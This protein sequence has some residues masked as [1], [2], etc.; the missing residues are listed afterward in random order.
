MIES[1]TTT[2]RH[3]IRRTALRALAFAYVLFLFAG[4]ATQ[5]SLTAAGEAHKDANGNE[6]AAQ[7][8]PPPT[9]TAPA[10]PNAPPK[11]LLPGLF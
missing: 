3:R 7:P 5:A 10:A 9:A 1:M 6:A 2:G 4:C 8:P 11:Q